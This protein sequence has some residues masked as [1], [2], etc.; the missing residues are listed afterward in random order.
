LNESCDVGLNVLCVLCFR[1]VEQPGDAEYDA[2]ADVK[3]SGDAV[4]HAVSLHAVG[5]A[6]NSV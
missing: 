1:H 4:S 2:A 5:H 6:V 3:P